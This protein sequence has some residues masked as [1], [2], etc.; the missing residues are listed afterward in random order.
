MPHCLGTRVWQLFVFVLSPIRERILRSNFTYYTRRG[1]PL[2]QGKAPGSH[3][4]KRLKKQH[5]GNTQP[6]KS[7]LKIRC[8]ETRSSE[9]Q[10]GTENG[11]IDFD[12]N[13]MAT[14]RGASLTCLGHRYHIHWT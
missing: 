9:I 1:G 3:N 4:A 8:Q 13:H 11:T 5:T 7:F 6:G 10:T 12:L 14:F 2:P